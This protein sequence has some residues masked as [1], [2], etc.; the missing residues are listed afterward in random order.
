M[1]IRQKYKDETG[2]ESFQYGGIPNA[3]YVEWLESR[4][5]DVISPI[6][7]PIETKTMKPFNL[8]EA[9]AGKPVCTRVGREARIICFDQKHNFKP[10]IAL[11]KINSFEVVETFTLDGHATLNYQEHRNDLLM[12]SE[13]KTGWVNIYQIGDSIFTKQ[14]IIRDNKE[15]VR[16]NIMH[17][18]GKHLTVGKITWEE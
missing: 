13:V 11:L 9:K 8:A 2:K 5:L 14:E 1:T 4:L 12:K 3:Q 17:T 10:I 6:T 18:H 16:E 15:D 7:K